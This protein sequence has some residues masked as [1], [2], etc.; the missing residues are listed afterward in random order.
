MKFKDLGKIFIKIIL[1]VGLL[2]LIKIVFFKRNTIEGLSSKQNKSSHEMSKA[3]A[4]Q[5]AELS[6]NLDAKDMSN[7]L[8]QLYEYTN[9]TMA[10]KVQ[11]G[12]SA[13]VETTPGSTL[14][15][16]KELSGLYSSL[17]EY[18]DGKSPSSFSSSSMTS[19]L[20]NPFS[21]HKGKDK[22]DDWFGNSKS[23]G[24]SKDKDDDWFGNSKGKSKDKDDDWFGNSKGK[25]KSKDKD[26]DWFGNSKGNDK[27]KSKGSFSSDW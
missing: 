3:I 22:D 24:K 2:C 20:S 21:S 16:L 13:L 7:L 8:E 18:I 27:D 19:H 15:H 14:E 23:K 6:K 5:N 4:K 12:A 1:L 10:H 26:D 17:Y 11:A 25:G 9:L